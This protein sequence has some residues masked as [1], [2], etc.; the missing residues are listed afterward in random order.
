MANERREN[1]TTYVLEAQERLGATLLDET[2]QLQAKGQGKG[3]SN[4]IVSLVHGHLEPLES[5]WQEKE[6]AYANSTLSAEAV[7]PLARSFE[8]LV[9]ILTKTLDIAG[10]ARA[11]QASTVEEG[12]RSRLAELG[13]R[14]E[15]VNS[16][17]EKAL[18][19]LLEKCSLPNERLADFAAR[20]PPP[21]SWFDEDENLL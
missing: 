21:Q 8:H 3:A 14:I 13:E 17:A 19:P 15:S 6:E 12:V 5:Q 7:P 1:M 20:N 16:T 9:S 11:G 18:A 10:S 4:L 2:E